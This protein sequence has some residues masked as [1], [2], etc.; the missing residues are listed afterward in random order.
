MQDKKIRRLVLLF[1]HRWSAP[2]L[3]ELHKSEGG[4]FVTLTH[5]LGVGRDS[6]RVT[7]DALI[8]HGWV[9]RNPGHGHPMRPE[10]RLTRAGVRIAPLCGRVLDLLRSQRL[11]EIGLN[12]WSMP[13]TYVL[14][15][16]GSRFSEVRA[17]LPGVT[18]RG[19]ALT[20]RTLQEAEIVTRSVS[21][22]YPPATYYNLIARGRKL[23]AVLAKWV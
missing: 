6:L 14:H 12:K 7:L 19:L 5:R 1:H 20:L 15:V 3:A 16:G 23:A 18:A 13:V 9:M 22:D 8:G 21:D 2:I 11:L 17:S 10:Y 4:K